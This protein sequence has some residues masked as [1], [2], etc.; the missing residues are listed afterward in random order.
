M[1]GPRKIWHPCCKPTT[2]PLHHCRR[3]NCVRVLTV[4]VECKP[5]ITARPGAAV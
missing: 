3:C 2:K 4:G 1:F 5:L